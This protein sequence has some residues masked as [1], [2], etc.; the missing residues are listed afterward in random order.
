[1][2][3]VYKLIDHFTDQNEQIQQYTNLKQKVNNNSEKLIVLNEI[4]KESQYSTSL[5]QDLNVSRQTNHTAVFGADEEDD[6]KDLENQTTYLLN[7][8]RLLDNNLRLAKIRNQESE[9]QVEQFKR[10][11][12][13]QSTIDLQI[14]T[15]EGKLRDLAK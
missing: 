11:L 1:M 12:R 5:Q 4:I 13:G 3:T 7:E 9:K 14:A 8:E 10:E 15:L 2:Q 6:L